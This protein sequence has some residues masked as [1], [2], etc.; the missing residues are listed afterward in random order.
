[1]LSAPPVKQN[2]AREK[3]AADQETA[4][5]IA[6]PMLADIDARNR[7]QSDQRGI[8]DE[9]RRAMPRRLDLC[10]GDIPEEPENRDKT[11]HVSA[12]EPIMQSFDF[13]CH[14]DEA[15]AGA[16]SINRVSQ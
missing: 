3:C 12:G 8:G 1:M 11:K 5:C 7:D 9:E 2:H 6:S 15:W 14:P 10:K 4:Q 16:R 13:L